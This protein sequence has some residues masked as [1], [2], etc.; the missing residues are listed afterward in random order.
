MQ[1]VQLSPLPTTQV[2]SDERSEKAPIAAE[3]RTP[4]KPM[5]NRPVS[6]I[7]QSTKTNSNREMVQVA[8]SADSPMRMIM[9]AMASISDEGDQTEKAQALVPPVPI[10]YLNAF[11]LQSMLQKNTMDENA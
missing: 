7:G 8:K 9:D 5:T 1:P 10:R 6:E 4:E 3:A 11:M 2:Y